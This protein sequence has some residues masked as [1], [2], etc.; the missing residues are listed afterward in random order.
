MNTQNTAQPLT[1]DL[2]VEGC[3]GRP[4]ECAKRQ[5]PTVAAFVIALASTV[6]LTF[7]G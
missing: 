2:S 3:A 7:A 6:V 5:L 4:L 1:T